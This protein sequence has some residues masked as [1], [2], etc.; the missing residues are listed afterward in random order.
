[1]TDA[2]KLKIALKALRFYAAP[3]TY[4]GV[5]ILGDRPCGPF[6]RDIG[7]TEDEFGEARRP[8]KRAREALEKIGAG[9]WPSE[10][11]G[12]LK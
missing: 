2:A 1:V 6:V 10:G 12:G 4:Y 3:G 7:L 8:G 11:D 5:A 9:V